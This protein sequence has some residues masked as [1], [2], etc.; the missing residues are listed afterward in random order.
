MKTKQ[1]ALNIFGIIINK[2][3][4]GA[5]IALVLFGGAALSIS[6]QESPA[7]PDET[8]NIAAANNNFAGA[9]IISGLT[10]SV[11]GNTIDATHETGEPVHA[12]VQGNRS[13]WYSWTAPSSGSVTF[14][15]DN[16]GS[17][18]TTLA[19][20]KGASLNALTPIAANDDAIT[21][22]GPPRRSRVTFGTQAGTVYR[23]AIDGH[24]TFSG[25]FMLLWQVTAQ[26]VN[27]NFD[28]ADNLFSRTAQSVTGTTIGGSKEPGE[29]NHF[30]NPGGKS[31][32]FKWIAP[33]GNSR[34]YTFS[35]R[36][37]TKTNLPTQSANTV[38]AVYSGTS[39]NA[40]TQVAG[41]EFFIDETNQVTFVPTPGAT[42]YIAVD[43]NN[44]GAGAETVNVVLSWEVSR[45]TRTADFDVD[46]KAD[47]VV[48]RPNIGTF[49]GLNSSDNAFA[50]AQWGTNGDKP[51][52]GDYDHDGITDYAVFRPAGGYWY[53][54]RS[55]TGT[56]TAQQWGAPGDV[57]A[58]GHYRARGTMLGVFRPSNGYWYIPSLEAVQF[59]QSG[60]V[61]ATA[62]Y[63]GD[64]YADIGVFRPS[65]G[66][67]YVRGANG[68]LVARQ[69]GT[70]GD[71]PVP[72]DYDGDGRVDYAVFRPSTGTWFYNL[73]FSGGFE[74]RQ[75]GQNGDVPVAGDYDGDN[76]ADFAVFRPSNGYWYI[77]ETAYGAM[78]AVKFGT[79]GDVPAT[80][81]QQIP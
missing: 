36:G 23:I 44:S 22:S 27:D 26:S 21:D 77:F 37:S 73:S 38:M 5:L 70:N 64:G 28:F 48:F 41:N 39:V 34:S 15:T 14:A 6:A 30:G 20:Y 29:P 32:W 12:G 42:Y 60:D 18:D 52:L 59:G 1:N 56:F 65:D 67:W 81:A 79:N 8:S 80:S 63:D 78:R 7:Q 58:P 16:N 40:L 76:Y 50:A 25:N 74:G 43:G 47:I 54:L 53:I 75:F 68:N 72:A 31:I 24:F 61:P 71:I 17:F 55:S 57:P 46:K 4:G 19:V 33:A 3:A 45:A 51:V 13:V 2:I 9:K 62:D 11:A 69:F 35:T 66:T 49:F 10:G